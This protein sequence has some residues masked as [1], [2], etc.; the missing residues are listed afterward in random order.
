MEIK[1][2]TFLTS[3]QERSVGSL[4]LQSLHPWGKRPWYTFDKRL[5]WIQSWSKHGDKEKNPANQTLVIQG[6]D[7]M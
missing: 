7:A 1:L 4:A 5:N 6:Y 2:H 3:E